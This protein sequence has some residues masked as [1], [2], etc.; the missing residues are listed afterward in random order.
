MVMLDLQKQLQR[1]EKREKAMKKQ[2]E[3]L[4]ARMRELGLQLEMKTNELKLQVKM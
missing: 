2:V 4:A 3:T 1:G